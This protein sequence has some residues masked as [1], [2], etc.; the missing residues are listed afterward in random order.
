MVTRR[1]RRNTNLGLFS[2]PSHIRLKPLGTA[3]THFPYVSKK[4]YWP[5]HILHIDIDQD[6]LSYTFNF[7]NHTFQVESLREHNFEYFLYIYWSWCWAKYQRRVHGTCKTL[8][9]DGRTEWEI[10]KKDEGHGADL[11]GDFFLFVSWKSSKLIE[12]CTD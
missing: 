1:N 12:F 8:C 10:I 5:S 4:V 11:F 7:G 2:H 9:L 3:S 6:W